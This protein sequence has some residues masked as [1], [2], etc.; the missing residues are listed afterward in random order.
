[1]LL[2][3]THQHL[4]DSRAP[5]NILHNGD[6]FIP[7]LLRTIS[8]LRTHAFNELPDFPHN[9]R[10][11]FSRVWR[12][13]H[14]RQKGVA[15]RVEQ[16]AQRRVV[17]TIHPALHMNWKSGGHS[18]R[19]RCEE[20]TRRVQ[21]GEVEVIVA[22]FVMTFDERP[23]TT[24][25]HP[26]QR[27]GGSGKER[28]REI[29]ADV[30]GDSV[31]HGFFEMRAWDALKTALVKEVV[32]LGEKKETLVATAQRTATRVQLGDDLGRIGGVEGG[33]EG[34]GKDCGGVEEEAA[35]AHEVYRQEN[36]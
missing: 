25:A 26:A 20:V 9:E 16:H 11:L 17:R 36:E 8:R 30:R 7:H 18:L 3:G 33:R 29:G 35:N 19:G 14:E 24:L 22:G 28:R 4:L 27:A 1:M 34:E 2:R 6:H 5:H 13:K 21:T 32:V 12:Q 15:F 10:S 23:V 31:V